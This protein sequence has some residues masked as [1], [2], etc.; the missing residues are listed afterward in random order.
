MSYLELI[1]A[2]DAV[3]LACRL[4]LPRRHPHYLRV[5]VKVVHHHA[6][7]LQRNGDGAAE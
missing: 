3:L 6:L 2:P 7:D 1:V 4:H 5:P